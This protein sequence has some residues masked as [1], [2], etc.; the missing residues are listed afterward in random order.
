MLPSASR[1]M[2]LSGIEGPYI[3]EKNRDELDEVNYPRSQHVRARET[4]TTQD[5]AV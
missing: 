1:S 5:G 4:S 2:K 3:D